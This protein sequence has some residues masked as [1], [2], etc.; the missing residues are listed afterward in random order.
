[1]SEVSV[2]DSAG[3]AALPCGDDDLQDDIPTYFRHPDFGRPFM[4]A[5]EVGAG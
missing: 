4:W 2:C 1:M 5:A 3:A